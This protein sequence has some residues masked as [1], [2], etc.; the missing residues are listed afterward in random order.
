MRPRRGGTRDGKGSVSIFS[1]D[2]IVRIIRAADLHSRIR[3]AATAPRIDR[4]HGGGGGVDVIKIYYYVRASRAN[5]IILE[6]THIIRLA[7]RDFITPEANALARIF[8]TWLF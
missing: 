6:T 2:V 7:N 3:P 1:I 8:L 5:I 4:P